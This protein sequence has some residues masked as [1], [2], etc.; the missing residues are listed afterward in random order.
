MSHIRK[1]DSGVT[2][3]VRT[4]AKVCA[5][6]PHIRIRGFSV[7]GTTVYAC[8]VCTDPARTR[9]QRGIG[10]K[11]HG[12]L[13][14]LRGSDAAVG[15]YRGLKRGQRKHDPRTSDSPPVA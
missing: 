8:P 2:G 14:S 12:A 7:C 5:R 1:S 15:V 4:I 9:A 11:F 3:H 6:H 13:R 10:T